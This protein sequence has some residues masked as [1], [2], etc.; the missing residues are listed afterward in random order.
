MLKMHIKKVI[1]NIQSRSYQK[2]ANDDGQHVGTL[3]SGVQLRPEIDRKNMVLD[4]LFRTKIN[5]FFEKNIMKFG[6]ML[7]VTDLRL[8]GH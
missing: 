8:L 5:N 4:L 6:A 1:S 7:M 3:A 2:C